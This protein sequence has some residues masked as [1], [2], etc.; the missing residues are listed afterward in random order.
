M[1]EKAKICVV[2]T[3]GTICSLPDANGKN[4]SDA[5]ETN[6]R[7]TQYYLNESNSPYKDEV[8]FEVKSLKP[9]TT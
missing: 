7:L 2:L 4:Q 5:K 1:Q 8:T 9:D 6:T 3:G